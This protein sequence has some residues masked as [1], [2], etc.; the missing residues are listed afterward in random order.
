M[1][2]L[3]L[4]SLLVR[5]CAE[6]PSQI[7]QSVLNVLHIEKLPNFSLEGN[8]AWIYLKGL[9]SKAHDTPASLWKNGKSQTTQTNCT[10]QD[11]HYLQR[12]S[13]VY[14]KKRSRKKM[15]GGS[16]SGTILLHPWVT[17]FGEMNVEFLLT[18]LPW[19]VRRPILLQQ[20]GGR[21]SPKFKPSTWLKR[22]CLLYHHRSVDRHIIQYLAQITLQL[23]T[24][25]DNT[26]VAQSLFGRH[27]VI[28]QEVANSTFALTNQTHE[29][30]CS[31]LI[32]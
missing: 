2:Q 23:N 22:K 18:L 32:L 25:L 6:A 21:D 19:T 12:H 7:V 27:V 28:S 8:S 26:T 15:G 17:L 20:L 16:S 5:V 30:E 24:H 3:C 11:S 13:G 1:R 9:S 31:F 10:R 29:A 14:M 4:L